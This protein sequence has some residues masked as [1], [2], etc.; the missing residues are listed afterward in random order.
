MLRPSLLA[1]AFALPTAAL[2]QEARLVLPPGT[3]DTLATVLENE[4]LTLS[5][6][7]EGLT[8][9]Q[10]YVAAARA[11]Y[12]RLLAGLYSEG[13]YGGVISILVDGR[14][15]STIQPLEA[16]PRVGE[17]VLSVAPGPRFTFGRI[18]IAP[19]A[20]NTELPLGFAPGEVARSETV[21]EAVAAAIE[22]WRQEGNAKAEVASED[23]VA[24]HPADRLDVAV[25]LAPGPELSFGPVTVTGNRDVRTQRILRI[26][27]IP[28]GRVFDPDDLERAATR[29]RRTGAFDSV[30]VVESEGIGPGNTLPIQLQVVESLPRRVGFGAEISTLDGLS[31]N[32]FWLHRNLLGGAE[33]L[34]VEAE[35]SDIGSDELGLGGG[36]EDYAIGASFSRP[37]TFS[38]DN[39]LSVSARL[40]QE[41]EEDI[42]RRQFS[43]SFGITRYVGDD[44]V[45]TGALGIL[46]AREE[47]ALGVRD[48]AL[49]T[50]PL[51]ATLDRR[52]DPQDARRGFYLALE[53][54]P[55]LSLTDEGGNGGRLYADG[56]VFRSFGERFRLAAR[57][58][59]GSVFGA[60]RDEVPQEFLFFSGGG[61]TVRGQPFR[62]L[63]VEV[64]DPG[65]PDE[66]LTLGGA[67]F[68]GLQL[69]G[70]FDINET[71]GAVAFAD[72]GYVGEDA[73]PET[74][75]EF[76]AGVG[77]G[78]RYNSFIGPIRLDIATPATG[79]DAFRQ[80]QL[81]VGI[82][83]AF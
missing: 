24:V 13:Y 39:D 41:D 68:A 56:R 36:G 49:L 52:D 3:D 78:V 26:A 14:E 1:L 48:Y 20:P 29:L 19:L 5:L 45:L 69:E 53:A 67:S 77:V 74:D 46:A 55:F 72:A 30:A 12:R 8:S 7:A 37:A 61:G 51:T 50:L 64:P 34:R 47:T 27:G 10:D 32:A 54:T 2:A 81:Y 23:I 71:F 17:V 59:I 75:G 83:Q 28:T 9:P 70:R 4:S 35:V 44:L 66:T 63:G 15:A 80:V 62:S 38:P 11:D 82:G 43:L 60:E 42:F 58:Q 33:R 21:E 65:N 31:A 79:D 6:R 40:S 57:G 16:P 73:F 22:A 25:G 76:H 18:G